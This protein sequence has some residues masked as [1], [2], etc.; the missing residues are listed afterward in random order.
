MCV[1]GLQELRDSLR[2]MP[3][4]AAEHLSPPP[5][6]SLPMHENRM[7]R[8]RERRPTPYYPLTTGGAE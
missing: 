2:I 4:P 8:L 5:K 6:K 7:N 1:G 3:D